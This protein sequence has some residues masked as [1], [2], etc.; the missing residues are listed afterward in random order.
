[1]AT[2]NSAAGLSETTCWSAATGLALVDPLRGANFQ[3]RH[4]LLALQA[5]EPYR[6]ARALAL[7]VGYTAVAGSRRQRT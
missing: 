6:V 2:S 5:G 4:L 3:T 7:E 1:M